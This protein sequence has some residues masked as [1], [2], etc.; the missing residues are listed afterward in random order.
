MGKRPVTVLQHPHL[1]PPTQSNATVF[2]GGPDGAQ[3][4]IFTEWLRQEFDSPGLHGL[5]RH[6]HVPVAGNEDDRHIRPFDS[7]AFLYLE[8]IES[9]KRK[10]QHQTARNESSWTGK[11]FLAGT[12]NLRPPAFAA[13]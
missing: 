13:D 6:G 8:T 4:R 12:E 5:D 9:W 3:Q 1:Y 11:E 7:D 2:E 10:I